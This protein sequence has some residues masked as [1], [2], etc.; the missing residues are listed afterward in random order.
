MFEKKKRGEYVDLTQKKN[1]LKKK[2]YY[3][4]CTICR[5]FSTKYN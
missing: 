1:G 4:K 2:R 5:L 3:D